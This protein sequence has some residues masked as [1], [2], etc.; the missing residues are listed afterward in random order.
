M[1]IHPAAPAF[2]L[3]AMA[4]LVVTII[5]HGV[6]F[7][8]FDPII[9]LLFYHLFTELSKLVAEITYDGTDND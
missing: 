1:Q 9:S 3:A 8:R 5:A 4:T 6:G 7:L 2:W